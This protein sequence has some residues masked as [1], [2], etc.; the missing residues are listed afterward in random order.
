VTG[1]LS[2]LASGGRL[3]GLAAVVFWTVALGGWY[4]SNPRF[5]QVCWRQV[6][7]NR[8]L[9]VG[10]TPEMRG[11]IAWIRDQTD[12]SARILLE[13][14]LRLLEP[15][16]PESTHWTPLLPHFLG[17]DER[18]FIGGVYHG[19]FIKHNQVASFGDF[20]LGGRPIDT[21]SSQDFDR[22]AGRYNLGWVICWSPLSRFW[23]DHHPGARRIGTL[24]RFATPDRPVSSNEHEWRI[25]V[26]RGGLEAA[27]RYMGEGESQYAVYQLD[28]PRSYFL[29]GK[30]RLVASGPNRVEFAD[31]EPEAG[32]VVLSLHWLETWRSDPPLRL[33]PEPASPDP[34]DFVKVDLDRPIKKLVLWNR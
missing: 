11:L 6:S 18:T 4:A 33:L 14:Q 32:A 7:Q 23:F 9:V 10:L 25:L 5:F 24:P 22:Y 28:R 2:R 15:T 26:G 19:A 17:K 12:L 27:R 20:Q 29:K 16:D 3:G 1:T 30:G 13:D 34:V 21:Y 31:V 8:P